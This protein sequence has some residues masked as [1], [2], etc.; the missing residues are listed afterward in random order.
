MP[1][2]CFIWQALGLACEA[3]DFLGR[4]CCPISKGRLGWGARFSC[5]TDQGAYWERRLQLGA[6]AW[7]SFPSASTDPYAHACPR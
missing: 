2:L 7:L 5:P 4:D 1:A 6:A 3:K